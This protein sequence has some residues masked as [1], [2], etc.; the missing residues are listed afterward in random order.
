MAYRAFSKSLLTVAFV[1]LLAGLSHAD[2]DSD[3][4]TA[5]NTKLDTK[6]RLAACERLIAA[7]GLSNAERA[8]AL[9][10]RGYLYRRVKKYDAALADLDQAEKLAPGD[11]RIHRYRGWVCF[12]T[13]K[14][15][16]ADTEFSKAVKL[17]P[18][19]SWNYYMRAR[20]R[21]K[22]KKDDQALK[23]YEK[24]LALNP[25][26]YPA[27]DSRARMRVRLKDYAG[28]VKD[29]DAALA[30]D[31][32]YAAAYTARG[33]AYE[34]LNKIN[35]ALH[36]QAVA[37][38]LDPNQEVATAYLRRLVKKATV[39]GD[40]TSPA[41]F[42]QPK[43][44]MSISYL[45]TVS[46]VGPKMDEMEIAIRDIAEIFKN[47]RVPK[48]K[49]M[50]FLV[51]RVTAC[52]GDATTVKATKKH[53]EIDRK[54][55]G[56]ATIDYHRTLLPTV[57]PMGAESLT[58]E[59]DQDPLKALW[60]LKAGSKSAGGAKVFFVGPDPLTPRA[61]FLGC[62]KPGDKIPC[63]RITWTGQVVKY[64]KVT[65]PAGVFDTF[66]IRLREDTEM[67]MFGR[68][69]KSTAVLTWWYAP[70]VRWWVKRARQADKEIVINQAESIN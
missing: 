43:K 49:S 21:S 32:Y 24:V 20:T 63:G 17:E 69:K 3:K 50:T 23:D 42:K 30:I 41:V 68:S 46:V 27:Y 13:K 48:P 56:A 62:K 53:P 16:Q 57:L 54:K 36:D 26:Y 33:V 59:F 65:V 55:S 5:G 38:A 40:T 19:Y 64:D 10:K 35:Q 8:W 9:I 61:R 34:K 14:Y 67:V 37:V 29:C 2:K 1:L 45:R 52:S 51:R 4:R 11:P 47:K 25:R 7:K 44:N 6:T 66:V 15:A 58:I 18:R 12:D 28:A 31:P 60:P 22:L 39:S 70:S